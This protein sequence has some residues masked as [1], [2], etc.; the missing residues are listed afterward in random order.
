L[1]ISRGQRAL[2]G[3]RFP[4]EGE[5]HPDAANSFTAPVIFEKAME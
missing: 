2:C 3:A 4:R 1:T 5:L